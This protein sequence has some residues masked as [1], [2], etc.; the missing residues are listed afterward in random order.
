LLLVVLLRV[1]GRHHPPTWD[2][3][4]PLDRARLA[5]AALTLLIFVACFTP[6]PIEPYELVR[7]R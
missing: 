4:V 6:S 1:F 7:P 3:H 5:V 2:E